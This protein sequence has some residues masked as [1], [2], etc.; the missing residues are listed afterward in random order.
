MA[1][2]TLVKNRASTHHAEIGVVGQLGPGTNEGGDTSTVDP[3]PLRVFPASLFGDVDTQPDELLDGA[4]SQA[5]TANLVA[6]ER[7]LLQ[8]G[9]MQPPAGKVR[10]GR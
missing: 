1:S 4:R 5:I 3:Q 9:D 10:S 2:Q 7:H 8:Q 6:G